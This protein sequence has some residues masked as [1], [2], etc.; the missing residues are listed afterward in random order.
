MSTPRIALIGDHNPEITAH[1]GI[2]FALAIA[3][4]AVGACDWEWLHTV[5][6][7]DDPS[8]RLAGFQGIWCVPGSPYA[9]T[10]GALAAIRWARQ[11]GHPFLGTCGGFQHALLEYAEA[12]WGMAGAAHAEMDPDAI[13][14]VITPLTCDLVEQ[15]GQVWF[16]PGSRL[17]AIYGIDTVTEGYHCRYGLN[18][19][20]ADRLAAGPLMASG[21]DAAGNVRAIELVGH[22]FFIATL[23]QP[24]RSGLANS[25][26]PLITAFVTAVCG[27]E[28]A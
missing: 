3:A 11:T 4:E 13:D 25:R 6:L 10:R 26:H 23:F 12:V 21:H 28:A 15:A 18:P 24:E 19:T 17:A 27:A 2:P 7:L 16:E 22:P 9:S 1:Q 5:T 8:E 20:Y 14:P